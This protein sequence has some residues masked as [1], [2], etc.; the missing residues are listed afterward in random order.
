MVKYGDGRTYIHK[1]DDDKI[2]WITTKTNRSIAQTQFL[3]NLL[4][5]DFEKLKKLEE[6]IKNTFYHACPS[7]IEIVERLLKEE[8]RTNLL[9]LSIL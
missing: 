5:G 2:K 9:N 4:G 1:L 3:F 7:N 8:N 6:K